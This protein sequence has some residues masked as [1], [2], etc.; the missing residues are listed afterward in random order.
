MQILTTT[1][2]CELDKEVL[3]H[4]ERR[5]EKLGR[6]A[7]D[8][9][10][11][12]LTVTAERYR[13]SAEITLRLNHHELVSREE[14]TEAKIAIDLAADRLEQQLRRFK[15][16]RVGRKR[17]PRGGGPDRSDAGNGGASPDQD[18]PGEDTD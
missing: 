3:L 11:A 16:K 17:G 15:E 5:L 7:R 9:R 12:H 10:E 14:S 1:R 13:H 18:S 4:A 2:H 8:I 6:F